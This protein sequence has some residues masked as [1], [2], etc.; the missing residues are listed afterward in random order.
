[1][2]CF[3]CGRPAD[4]AH[5]VVPEVL[6]GTQTIPLCTECHGKVH[7]RKMA[8]PNLIRA[9][10]AAA[11]AEGKR[12]GGRK[13][14]TRIKVTEEKEAAA[15]RLKADKMPITKIALTLGLTRRTVY[16]ILQPI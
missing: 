15:H 9:G 6:G 16:R 11:R 7:G 13:V 8:H 12:W 2:I 3:E 1:M 4:H 14:G 10:I 5:H